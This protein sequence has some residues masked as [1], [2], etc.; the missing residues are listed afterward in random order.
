MRLTELRESLTSAIERVIAKVSDQV[1]E[2]M[3]P[4]SEVQ[5]QIEEIQTRL[6]EL[7]RYWKEEGLLMPGDWKDSLAEL[8]TLELKIKEISP[9]RKTNLNVNELL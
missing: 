1:N 2:L 5:S 3:D 6:W 4:L 7:K 9:K 8:S